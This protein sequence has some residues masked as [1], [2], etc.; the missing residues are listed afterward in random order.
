MPGLGTAA[1]KSIGRFMELMEELSEK[2]LGGAGVGDLIE[3][4]LG[5][6]GYIETLEAERSVEA[7]GRVENL[8]S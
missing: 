1:I 3:S 5:K 8:R 7:E 6:T 2:A 4:V